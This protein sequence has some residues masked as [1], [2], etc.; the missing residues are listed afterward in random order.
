MAAVDL[1]IRASHAARRRFVRGI[2]MHSFDGRLV[3]PVI[4]FSFDDFPRSALAKG[5]RM[6]REAGWTGTYYTAGAFCGRIVDG[7]EYFSRDDLIQV[8][9]DGHEIGCHTF[10]HMSLRPLSE[11]EILDDLRCNAAFIRDILPGHTFSSFAYP[12]G[13]LRLRNK[14][15]LGK[16]FPTCRGVGGGLNVGRMDFAQLRS[17]LL[18]PGSFEELRIESWLER[19]V[20]SK[21][22][23][24]FFTHDISDRPSPYGCFTSVFAKIIESIN[25]RGIKVLSVKNAAELARGAAS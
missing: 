16:Q 15:L 2:K 9:R 24:I 22:W 11:P 21:G 5:G 25:K 1:C 3:E 6:L 18:K 4:S 20:A 19:A 14:G 7:I 8:D 12:F 10:N 13:E 23:L 17:V